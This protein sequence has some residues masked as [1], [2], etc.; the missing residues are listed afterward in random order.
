[1]DLVAA[2]VPAP[3]PLAGPARIGGALWLLMAHIEGRKAAVGHTDAAGYRSLGRRLAELHGAMERLPP[4]PQRPG[5]IDAPAAATPLP[6]DGERTALLA[7][8]RTGA[9]AAAPPLE[10]ALAAFEARDL[11]A[12]FAGVPRQAI[13]A[14]FTP[15][16]TIVRGG[17]LNGVVDFELAHLDVAAADLACSRRGYHDEVVRGY[18]A[19]RPLPAAQLA[20]L[21]ALWTGLLV[22]SL[23]TILAGWRRDGV[24]R[25][26]DLDWHLQQL[27]KTKPY[28]G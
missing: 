14:D 26:Q 16:N 28:G 12:V 10:A 19:V 6:A 23:W 2:G 27:G 24:A 21:D 11:P 18:L 13:H 15:W 8:L 7:T 4:R 22:S 9:P 17:R 20:A 1:M 3:R 5:W 25:P